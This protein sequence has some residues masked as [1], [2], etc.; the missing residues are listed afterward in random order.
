MLAFLLA[1]VFVLTGLL[2]FR[3]VVRA[4]TTLEVG[5][6]YTQIWTN[7]SSN[8]N[9][10]SA[11]RYAM[12]PADANSPAPERSD[13]SG[14]HFQVTGTMAGSE[15]VRIRFSVPGYYYYNV[16]PEAPQAGNTTNG[17][18]YRMSENGQQG[19]SYTVMLMVLNDETSGGLRMAASGPSEIKDQRGEKYNALTMLVDYYEPEGPVPTN[20]P[21]PTVPTPV[22]TN[23]PAPANPAPVYYYY[24]ASSTPATTATP[25]PTETPTPTP[26]PT[27]TPTPTPTA[28]PTPGATATPTPTPT[29][30]PEVIEDEDAP[31]AKGPGEEDYWALLNLL[32]M[33]GTIVLAIVEVILFFDKRKSDKENPNT[34]ET[35]GTAEDD[36]NKD[37]GGLFRLLTLIP[38]VAAPILFFLTE[39]IT[40]RMRW[41]DKWTI[42]MIIILAINVALTI[43]AQATK[44]KS[45]ESG[46]GGA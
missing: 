10:S 13:A 14:Y 38:A 18:T 26:T 1:A 19:I 45:S 33:I 20:T 17:Y 28:T 40:Q 7:H 30:T 27:E 37:R 4:D 9:A 23:A 32:C 35:A 16:Y 46:E 12:V 6:P 25:T 41:T 29:P 22:P 42:W 8:A 34:P 31:L 15:R 11:V 44:G 2:P 24:P 21:A 43:A 39:D 5:I 3:Q 36:K